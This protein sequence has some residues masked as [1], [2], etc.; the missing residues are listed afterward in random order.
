MEKDF[1]DDLMSGVCRIFLGMA[2]AYGFCAY[3]YS[4]RIIPNTDPIKIESNYADPNKIRIKTKDLDG[5]GL[6]EVLMGYENKD[7]LIT[8]DKEGEPRVQKY[9]IQPK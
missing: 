2:L 1:I 3:N 4:G 6:E 5:N 8:L 7:Y 9:V